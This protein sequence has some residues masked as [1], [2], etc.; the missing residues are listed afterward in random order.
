[1]LRFLI[2]HYK[3]LSI[4]LFSILGSIGMTLNTP[5][6]VDA[7]TEF[8]VEV[9]LN[10]GAIEGFARY[11]QKLPIGLTAQV[12]ESSAGNFSF[13]DQNIRVIW[14]SLPTGKEIRLKYKIKVDQRLSGNFDLKSTFS[15]I[16][17][18]QKKT[19]SAQSQTINI[20]TSSTI[21]P[22]LIVD[23]NEFQNI[24]PAQ[25][26]VS[27]MAS[28][29]S[30][31]CVRQT[32]Y[33]SGEG[34]DMTVNLLIDK[35]NTQ[36]FA[37]IE[38]TIPQGF[39]AEAIESKEAVFTFKEQKA[40]FIWMS[41]PSDQRF[42]VSYRLIPANGT[43][44]TSASITGQ[45]S[46][47]INDITKVVDIMQ[48]DID[49]RN[50]D[51]SNIDGLLGIN[52]SDYRNV[53]ITTSGFTNAEGGVEIP[54]K[55]QEIKDKPKQKAGKREF[56][57]QPYLLI[58]ENGVYYRV[59]VAAGHRPINI[60]KYFVRLNIDYEVRTE[61][62]E[63]WYKYSIGSFREYKVARDFRI[64]I[65]NTSKANDA[66]VAAYNN[67]RRITVQEALMITNQQWYR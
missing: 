27:L 15:Y 56:N 65:W 8:E 51:A 23:I 19:E 49:L 36:K 25:R 2:V 1:M 22:N 55:Y 54:I 59:Q 34:N 20:R 57:M 29:N 60:K 43:G 50:I 40:K 13:E 3:M 21:D 17:E 7:G 53:T 48:K 63:G 46:Y 6:T 47:V 42:L 37:K 32:P 24:I 4:L 62:H 44:S 58:P 64:N 38:E 26:P 31:K 66:F 12:V 18:N 14:L 61:Q 41:L 39:S 10:K 45:F 5:T 67:G 52:T 9:V 30:I 16:S 35:G 11:Q 28:T 33:P